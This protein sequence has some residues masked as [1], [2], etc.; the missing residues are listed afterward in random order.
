[1]R[2]KKLFIF[3][4]PTTGLHFDDIAKLLICFNELVQAGHSLIV[5][6]HN[7]DVVKCA[8]FVIDLG[9]DAGA[10]G[11]FIVGTGT[12]EEIAAIKK[13]HTGRFFKTNI[14]RPEIHE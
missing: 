6:E 7:M 13:S 9:P 10:E 11:G 5:I 14:R 1:M 3:D 2:A 12:P 4:E 8:D